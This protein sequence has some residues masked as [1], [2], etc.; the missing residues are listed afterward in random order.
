MEEI[1]LQRWEIQHGRK[2]GERYETFQL[3]CTFPK[4]AAE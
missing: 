2:Q 4:R 1:A 3:V